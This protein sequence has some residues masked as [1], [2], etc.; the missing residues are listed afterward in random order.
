MLYHT[1]T[2]VSVLQPVATHHPL[3]Q[4]PASS[5]YKPSTD[6]SNYIS[7]LNLNTTDA[8]SLA[9]LQIVLHSLCSSGDFNVKQRKF[10]FGKY[11]YFLFTAKVIIFLVAKWK[12]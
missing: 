6:H 2:Y 3:N 7:H 9:K 8:K 4:Q 11:I 1:T 5:H 10:N 12:Q